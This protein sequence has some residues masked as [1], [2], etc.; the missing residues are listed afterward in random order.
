[1]Q[2][3]KCANPKLSQPGVHPRRRPDEVCQRCGRTEAYALGTMFPSLITACDLNHWRERTAIGVVPEK[4]QSTIFC[5]L[6]V[7]DGHPQINV[8]LHLCDGAQRHQATASS[9][10][11]HD[12]ATPFHEAPL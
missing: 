5:L 9:D 1:M 11:Q 10:Y 3:L 4:A 6:I 2:S 8:L 7:F 12:F